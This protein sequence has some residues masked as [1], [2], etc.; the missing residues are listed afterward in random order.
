MTHVHTVKHLF[1]HSF[2]SFDSDLSLPTF[3]L[4]QLEES[5]RDKFVGEDRSRTGAL[6]NCRTL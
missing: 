5:E 1:S 6:S 4:N 2:Q 3:P